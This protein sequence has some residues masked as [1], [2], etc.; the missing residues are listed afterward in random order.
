MSKVHIISGPGEAAPTPVGKAVIKGQ[1]SVPYSSPKE[2]AAPDTAKGIMIT[3][4]K[5]GMR[6]ALRGGRFKSC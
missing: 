2:S 1:G 3:G 5:K 4:K 6:A